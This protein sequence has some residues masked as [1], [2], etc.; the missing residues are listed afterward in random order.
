MNASTQ[1]Y[2]SKE[3]THFLGR[4]FRAGACT[5]DE[6]EQEQYVL[7]K[8][9]ISGAVLAKD[10]DV[11]SAGAISINVARTFGSG[12]KH[13]PSC[14][15]FCDIPEPDLAIHIPKYSRFGLSFLKPF[16]VSQ[17]ANPVWYVAKDS[18]SIDYLDVNMRVAPRPYESVEGFQQANKERV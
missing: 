9:I 12:E 1:R 4:G 11:D 2:V 5:P 10:G 8:K 6:V 14:V 13:K 3:L 18:M 15:C 16:L 7:L 17:G